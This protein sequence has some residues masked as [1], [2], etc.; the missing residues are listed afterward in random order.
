[1][2]ALVRQAITGAVESSSPSVCTKIVIPTYALPK[3]SALGILNA[4]KKYVIVGV[5]AVLVIV[6][7]IAVYFSYSTLS[8]NGNLALGGSSFGLGDVPF[9]KLASGTTSDVHRRTNYLVDSPE[10]FAA[11]WQLLPGTPAMPAVDFNTKTVIALFAGD[12]P[13]TGYDL[14]VSS[15]NDTASTRMVHVV[16]NKPAASC[17]TGQMVTQPYVVFEVSKTDLAFSHTD[18]ETTTDCAQ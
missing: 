12:R 2:T 16:L 5:V 9:E 7:G 13:T 8:S 18:T 1:M 10:K 4:M 6:A 11:L 17:I 15:I 3:G 14:S